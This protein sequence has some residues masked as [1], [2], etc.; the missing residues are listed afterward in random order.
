MKTTAIN[1]NQLACLAA[2]K[3]FAKSIF[4]DM[5]QKHKAVIKIFINSLT[6]LLL[7]D[8]FF[9]GAVSLVID[10]KMLVMCHKIAEIKQRFL[11]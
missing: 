8:S 10:I 7:F 5:Y 2:A 3:D 11:H 1:K 9:Q 6:S 4:A